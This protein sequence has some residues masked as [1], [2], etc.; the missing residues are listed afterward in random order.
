MIVFLEHLWNAATAKR[1]E[2]INRNLDGIYPFLEKIFSFKGFICPVINLKVFVIY[3][4][5]SQIGGYFLVFELAQEGFFT[6]GFLTKSFPTG[7]TFLLNRP[8]VAGALLQTPLWLIYSF[9]HPFPPNLQ[10]V[11]PNQSINLMFNIL[12][13]VLTQYSLPLVHRDFQSTRP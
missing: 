11:V 1:S 2:L 10:E 4:G 8:G 9:S 5:K 3:S 13:V 6:N 7:V 12:I